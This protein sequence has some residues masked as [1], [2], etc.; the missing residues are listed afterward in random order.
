MA[1]VPDLRPQRRDQWAFRS[2]PSGQ[3]LGLRPTF[4]YPPAVRK[5]DPHQCLH[6]ALDLCPRRTLQ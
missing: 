3:P 4:L 1:K 2:R 5:L 6:T